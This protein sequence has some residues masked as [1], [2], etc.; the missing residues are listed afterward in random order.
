MRKNDK[1]ICPL[2]TIVLFLQRIGNKYELNVKMKIKIP[3]AEAE[4][5]NEQSIQVRMLTMK[6]KRIIKFLTITQN[7]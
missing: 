6:L 5:D 3:C 4:D 1:N 7:M 2:C